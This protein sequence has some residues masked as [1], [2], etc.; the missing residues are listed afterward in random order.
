MTF[1][2]SGMTITHVAFAGFI[3]IYIYSII[4]SIFKKI[5]KVFSLL[6]NK[7]QK[8]NYKKIVIFSIAHY[9]I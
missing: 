7:V 5:Q 8:I 6:I 1:W 4:L 2:H 3:Y 9:H